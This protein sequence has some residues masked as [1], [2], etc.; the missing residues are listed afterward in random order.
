[1]SAFWIGMPGVEQDPVER[2]RL[3]AELA[4]LN[5]PEHPVGNAAAR[6][7]PR[8][9]R[10]PNGFTTAATAAEALRR[11]LG[12]ARHQH[13]PR[14]MPLARH[15]RIVLDAIAAGHPVP[16]TVLELHGLPPCHTPPSPP[17]VPA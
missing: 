6:W 16:A 2:D 12:I 5:R 17:T 9:I 1:M 4:A 7:Q 13:P 11:R 3:R 15:R 10:D 14:D 8:C